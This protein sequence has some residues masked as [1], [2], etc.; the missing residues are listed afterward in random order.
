MGVVFYDVNNGLYT[1]YNQG[2]A[3]A[4]IG[5]KFV[6]ESVIVSGDNNDLKDDIYDANVLVKCFNKVAKLSFFGHNIYY[7]L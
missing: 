1:D 3:K 6:F 2:D 5:Q 7:I 4:E